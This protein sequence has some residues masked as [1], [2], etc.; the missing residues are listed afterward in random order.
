MAHAWRVGIPPPVAA[1]D[2][3]G[4]TTT[5]PHST[6]VHD[7][8]RLASSTTDD[9]SAAH[10][11]TRTKLQPLRVAPKPSARLASQNTTMSDQNALFGG[12]A[13]V[14][15]LHAAHMQRWSMVLA[16]R[17]DRCMVQA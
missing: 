10:D 15:A 4:G 12:R 17:A 5:D 7:V 2:E 14:R 16:P 3:T 6:H 9:A 8:A 1:D 11:E 13:A